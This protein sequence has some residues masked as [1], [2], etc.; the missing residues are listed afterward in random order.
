MKHLPMRLRETQVEWFSQSGFSW[1]IIT[2]EKL[3]QHDEKWFIQT[4]VFVSIIGD[5]SRQDSP[6]NAAIL[7]GK[8]SLH[9]IHL[10]QNRYFLIKFHALQI[11]I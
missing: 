8:P 2:I 5:D 4:D 9:F 1:H 10:V 7:K 3:I 11:E 6:V